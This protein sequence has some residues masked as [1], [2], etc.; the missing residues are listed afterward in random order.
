VSKGSKRAITKTLL[1]LTVIILTIKS[2]HENLK[3]VEI[4][5]KILKED[6]LGT[7]VRTTIRDALREK[8]R[9][10]R[11]MRIETKE[12]QFLSLHNL[13]PS[14][15]WELTYQQIWLFIL[16]DFPGLSG[17]APRLDSRKKPLQSYCIRDSATKRRFSRFTAHL[18]IVKSKKNTEISAKCTHRISV[19]RA[20]ANSSANGEIQD[21]R[22]RRP[23]YSSYMR[24]KSELYLPTLQL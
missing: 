12:G 11:D 14:A 17:I 18:G 24:Y 9:S 23:F 16:R 1:S 15:Q 3:L 22:C 6:I 8:W 19:H 13:T 10:P 7:K 5:V 20:V 4:G 2:L 21:Q